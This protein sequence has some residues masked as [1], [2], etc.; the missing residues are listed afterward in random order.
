MFWVHAGTQARFEEGYRRIAEAT[1]LDGWNNPKVNILRLVRSWLCD[2]SNGKWVMIVDNADN[3]EVFFSPPRGTQTSGGPHPDQGT[4]LLA[5]FLPQSLNGSI[6]ITSRSR[7]VALRLVESPDFILEVRPMDEGDALT[8]L[9][10]KL[11]SPVDEPPAIELLRALDFMPL[12]ITQAAAHIVQRAPRMTLS[13]YLHEVRRSDHSRARLLKKD[14]GDI[15]RDGSASNSILATWYISF[16][17]IRRKMPTAARLL[18]LMSL[19][20]RQGIPERLLHGW[21]VGDGNEEADFEDDIYTLTTY[22]L[23]GVSADG[24]EFE[25][26]RL[27]Q[28]STRAWLELN[29]TLEQWKGIYAMLLDDRYPEGEYEN[30]KVCQSLF[31]HVQAAERNQPEDEEAQ[32]AWASVLF[33]AAWYASEIGQYAVAH[34]MGSAAFDARERLL[35]AEHP[36]T[37]SSLTSIGRLLDW[38]GKYEKAEAT[39]KRVLEIKRRVLGKEHPS[40]LNSMFGVASAYRNQGRWKEAEE[41]FLQTIEMRKK[42][43]GEEHPDT[44]ASISS[45]ALT[46]RDQGRLKEAEEL[47]M[48]VLEITKKVLGEEHPDTLVSIG[49]LASTYRDQGRLKEAEEL[50]MQVL[51]IIKKVLGEEHPNTLISIGNLASTYVDQ[52]RLKEAE[53]LGMQVLEIRKKVLGE[54]HPDTL[55]SMC[56]LALTLKNL[57]RAQEA[58][59]LLEACFK[60]REKVLG[61]QHPDTALSLKSL[62]RWQLEFL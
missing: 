44:F 28:F 53:E 2:E 50:D 7:A 62:K 60:L 30:W 25:L 1:K 49:N 52:G 11:T 37:L 32:K 34:R 55:L 9:R 43:L 29:R 23:I 26:H 24:S 20:D 12:A 38:Q 40:T 27:V 47:G 46:Y 15:R 14:S 33:K 10:K 21:Y 51:E 3:P 35:G 48:Q 31:P 17:Y 36:D 58:V 42:V 8:L 22:S 41:L 13:G 19:F 56:N 16:E 4:E 57:G 59:L 18:S 61:P 5:E 39:H 54:E 45:L 6:L